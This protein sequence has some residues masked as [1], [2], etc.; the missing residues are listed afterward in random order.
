MLYGPKR[1][2]VTHFGKNGLNPCSNGICSTGIPT[3]YNT[4]RQRQVLILVLMEYALR[5]ESYSHMYA[6]L[7]VLILVLME[8]ALRGLRGF[9]LLTSVRVL[10]LVLMEYALRVPQSTTA[11]RFW[12]S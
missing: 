12:R 11:F 8:Y 4:A 9:R 6:A 3:T 2:P 5:D 10:I 7:T 1:V